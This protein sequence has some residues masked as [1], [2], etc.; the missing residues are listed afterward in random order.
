MSLSAG[1]Q[2]DLVASLMISSALTAEECL[3]GISD[4]S[5]PEKAYM[6]AVAA[7]EL[8]NQGSRQHISSSWS[9]LLQSS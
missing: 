7:S 6:A 2:V 3:E 9:F 4:D 8:P 5:T 1:L